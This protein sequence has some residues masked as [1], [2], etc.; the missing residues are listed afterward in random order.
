MSVQE[1]QTRK[2]VN[3]QTREAERL[4][5]F[6][7]A[8]RD[9]TLERLRRVPPGRENWRF[10]PGAMSFADLAQHLVD[11]D[12]WLFKK[13]K[14]KKLDPILGEAGTVEITDRAE[15]LALIDALVRTGD[16]RCALLESL[17]DDQLDEK[18]FDA[19][20]GGEVSLWWIIVRGNLDHEIHH[21]GQI[22]S[23]LRAVDV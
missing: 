9:S 11:T 23:Y 10:A 21:R 3:T 6:A 2:H 15:Y 20:F 5:A 13:I 19:R 7:H 1:T 22:A 12:E 16:A 17:T 14:V 4:V 18:I 8:V